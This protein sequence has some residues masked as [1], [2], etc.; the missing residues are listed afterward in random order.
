MREEMSLEE[1]W[2]RSATLIAAEPSR[3]RMLVSAAL[4]TY[5]AAQP[6][7]APGAG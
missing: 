7:G 2:P 4:E 6:R 1:D 3:L 5:I